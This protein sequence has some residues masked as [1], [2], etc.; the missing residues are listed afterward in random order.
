MSWENPFQPPPA[1]PRRAP[2][3]PPVQSPS[4]SVAPSPPKRAPP[5]APQQDPTR[6][7]D[8][9][10]RWVSSKRGIDHFGDVFNR[11]DDPLKSRRKVSYIYSLR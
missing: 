4:P 2:P 6:V 1:S 9:D 3:A 5:S 10:G 11:P 8:N 7:R